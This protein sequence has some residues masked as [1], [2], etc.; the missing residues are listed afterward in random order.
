MTVRVHPSR[1][2]ECHV[3]I[4]LQMTARQA[5]GQ[6]RD[7]H[8]YA[9]HDQFHAGIAI[10]DQTPKAGAALQIDHRYGPFRIRRVGRILAWREGEGYAFSDLSRRGPRRGF[11]HVMAMHVR[12]SARGCELAIRVTGLWTA[13]TPRW[14]AK[15]WLRWVMASITQGVRNDLLTFALTSRHG[16]QVSTC[17]FLEYDLPRFE[18]NSLNKGS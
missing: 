7:F 10:A 13:R 11:P 9:S 4:A 3:R 14:V 8:R 17:R 18:T 6:L 1:R 16:R 2:V 15:L 12:D 5:W